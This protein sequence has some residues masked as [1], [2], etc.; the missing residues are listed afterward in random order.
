[1]L[2]ADTIGLGKGRVT[3]SVGADDAHG[4]AYLTGWGEQNPMS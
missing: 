4:G 1:V 2:G 3:R